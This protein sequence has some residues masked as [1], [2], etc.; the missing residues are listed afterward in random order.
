MNSTFDRYLIREFIKLVFISLGAFI[1]IYL[2]VDILDNIDTYIDRQAPLKSVVLYYVYLCPYI[3]VL[4]LPIAMLLASMLSVGGL[5]RN[6]E[7]V[8]MKASG[9][10]LYRILMPVWIVGLLLSILVGFVGG[11]IYPETNVRKERIEQEEIKRKRSRDDEPKRN[12]VYQ[13]EWGRIYHVSY[14]RPDKGR[15]E[16][17]RIISGEEGTVEWRMDARFGVYTDNLWNLTD[18]LI[19]VFR[20][21]REFVAPFHMIRSTEL[22]VSPTD[23]LG[24]P[25]NPEE[26][27]VRELTRLISRME[28]SGLSAA[29]QK[30]ELNLRFSFPLANFLMVLLGTPLASNPRRSGLALS[31]GLSIAI[32]FVFF[33]SIRACQALGHHETLHPALAAW[34]PDVVF[35]ITGSW[36]LVKV[37][38]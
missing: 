27:G 17:I 11:W 7:L 18:G 33:G 4:T 29:K 37:R 28:R 21:D 6:N 1:V 20:G 10:S 26:L 22:D 3:I 8:A 31:F 13:D 30:V 24:K 15:A 9:V 38:K 32:S 36:I 34:I 5:A 23:L 2:L 19:R 14:L 12:L 35:F 16:G 25:R